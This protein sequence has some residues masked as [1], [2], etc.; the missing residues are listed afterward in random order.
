MYPLSAVWGRDDARIALLLN[1]VHPGIGGVLLMGAKGTG[2]STLAR[3]LGGLLPETRVFNIPLG[4]GQERLLGGLDWAAVPKTALRSFRP[5]LLSEA[6]GHIVHLD[7]VN[8]MDERIVHTV[9][10]AAACGRVRI[11]RDGFSLEYPC[12]FILVASMHPEGGPLSAHILDRFGLCAQME[13]QGDST[14]RKE[15]LERCLAY[16]SGSGAFHGEWEAME[17]ALAVRI[18]EA[19]TRIGSTVFPDGLHGSAVALS[20]EQG[21]LGH[22]GE[23]ALCRAA[24]A[25]AAWR[26]SE[27]VTEDHLRE[28]A[29]LA[30]N[31]RVSAMPR[32]A[33]GEGDSGHGED[34][35]PGS[36]GM[37]ETGTSNASRGHG[38]N[39][40]RQG[41][42]R[43]DPGK[44]SGEGMNPSNPGSHAPGS[45]AS[46]KLPDDRWI[47]ILTGF[48]APDMLQ[49]QKEKGE[50]GAKAP[51]GGRGRKG[52]SDR[53]A[54]CSSSHALSGS[55]RRDISWNATLVHALPLQALRPKRN[56]II[57][58]MPEDLMMKAHKGK[59]GRILVFLVDASGSMGAGRRMAAAK[60]S[61]LSALKQ[62]YVNR[63]R[64]ALLVFRKRECTLRLPLTRSPAM[65]ERLLKEIP[66]GGETPLALGLRTAFEYCG[67]LKGREP[68]TPVHLFLFSDGRAN[69]SVTGGDPV[70]EAMAL[71]ARMG[72]ETFAY[73]V[74]DTETG[75]V[76][77]GLA[78]RI[79]KLLKASYCRLEELNGSP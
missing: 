11:E 68:A 18:R 43:R 30:L 15:I 54:A 66:T 65:A 40:A 20:A 61:I 53:A 63:D 31:H 74:I 59:A 73:S 2:K 55:A 60:G 78:Q 9:L 46:E 77:L 24:K 44:H 67:K 3:S 76:R 26:G 48:S 36:G 28:S 64:V 16:A 35:S 62:A 51:K 47:D 21:C 29:G 69:V 12:S 45:H 6:N 27:R 75:F 5:G 7:D 8:L 57:T 39:P 22:R 19:R 42:I 34:P 70:G 25:L 38:G 17:N 1:L 50:K 14:R 4:I 71:C 58:L 79:S 72:R 37:D 13:G 56:T 41:K 49:G 32:K 33:S 10:N 52:R 23:L